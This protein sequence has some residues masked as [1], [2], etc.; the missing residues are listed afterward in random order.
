MPDLIRFNDGSW[1]YKDSEGEIVGQ[2]CIGIG[3]CQFI[4]FSLYTH[5]R[6]ELAR[7]SITERQLRD[8]QLLSS[9]STGFVCVKHEWIDVDGAI[10][11]NV[12]Q[13]DE[14]GFFKEVDSSK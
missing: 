13:I 3:S 8:S 11:L 4:R 5:K 12:T 1:T 6:A 10:H 2:H 9:L 7:A 14:R